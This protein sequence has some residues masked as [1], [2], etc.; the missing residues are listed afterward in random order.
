M[1]IHFQLHTAFFDPFL[2]KTLTKQMVH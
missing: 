2:A 1:R